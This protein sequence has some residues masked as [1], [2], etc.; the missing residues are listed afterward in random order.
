MT[1]TR[2]RTLTALVTMTLGIIVGSS[3]TKTAEAQINKHLYSESADPTAD[4]SA[5][6]SVAR[7][8]HKRILLDFGGNWCGDCQLLDMYYRQ[9]ANAKL[10]PEHYVVVHIDIGHMDHNVEVAEK[11]HVPIRRGVPALAVLDAKGN[12]IY[13]ERDKEFEHSSAEAVQAFLEQWK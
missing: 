12:L 8:E 2:Y 3:V 11:Y 6:K 4:I 7:R 1:V 5:A 9:P 10:L 13:V